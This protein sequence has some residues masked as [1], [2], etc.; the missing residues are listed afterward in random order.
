MQIRL[1]LTL[2]F[3]AILASI[4]LATFGYIYV[5]SRA[6][7]QNDFYQ[8][9]RSKI[10]L[11]AAAAMSSIQKTERLLLSEPSSLI[12]VENIVI[13]SPEDRLVFQ[14]HTPALQTNQLTLNYIR[15]SGEL[16]FLQNGVA[17]L[18]LAYFSAEGKQFVIFAEAPYQ[19][20]KL[21]KLSQLLILLFFG[22]MALAASAGW[23]FAG[24]ALAPINRVMNQVESLAPTDLSKR[25]HVAN[26]KDEI[27]R[28]TTTFNLL[29]GRI[30]IAFNAQKML[31]TN[32][33]HELRNPLTVMKTQIQ[34]TLDK[35]RTPEAYRKTLQSV[36]EDV[37]E[38]SSA[39][40]KLMQF[41]SLESNPSA[42]VMTPIR[43]DE[44]LWKVKQSVLSQYPLAN[45]D[46]DISELPEQE[47]ELHV[48]ANHGL[49]HI[50]LLNLLENA[51]KFGNGFPV[52]VA[53]HFPAQLK[54]QVDIKD[55]G[56]GIPDADL[57]LIFDPFFRSANTESIKGSGVG[58]SL[59]K[60]ILDVH[61]IDLQ[62]YK[63]Q[64]QGTIFQLKFTK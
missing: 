62:V 1:R 38:L 9:L 18:G 19:D 42:L 6:Q 59:T 14:L 21:R 55:Q 11:S 32:I 17:G 31:M 27:S 56:I 29:L 52:V 49:I 46:L 43:M 20:T 64:P 33:A 24:Q 23:F 16:R 58:L 3:L 50:A 8:S 35:E 45:I 25:L 48:H 47:E 4:L 39:S 61:H 2:Q 5:Q 51:V 36:L 40:S 7:L 53:M 15:S 41:A 63:N 30:E 37:Q 12:A 10:F 28:L 60:R 22:I 34:I 57:A 13:Y 26:Q 54:M 44:M